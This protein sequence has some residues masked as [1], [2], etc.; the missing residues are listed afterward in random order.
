MKSTLI[1]TSALTLAL[2]TASIMPA[3]AEFTA[4]EVFDAVTTALVQSGVQV[5][6]ASVTLGS[7]DDV[8]ITGLTV[9]DGADAATIPTAELRD[10][11][12]IAD[13]VF[14]IGEVFVPGQTFTTPD[15]VE[16]TYGDIS[17]EDLKVASKESGYKELD[18]GFYSTANIDGISFKADD[19][20]IFSAASMD[21]TVTPF[22]ADKPMSSSMT[23]D[24]ILFNSSGVTDR[25]AREMMRALGYDQLRGDAVI[26]AVWDPSNGQL[27]VT[28]MTLSAE[29][30]ADISLTLDVRGYTAD[31][32]EAMRD[33]QSD[34][35]SNN[36]QASGM[37]MLGMLQQLEFHSMS[38]KLKDESLTGRVL[39]FVATQQGMDRASVT[40]LAKGLLPL[41]LS[42][43]QSPEFAANAQQAVSTYLDDPDTLTV[44]AKPD[45]AVPFALFMAPVM[46]GNPN[47]LLQILNVTVSAND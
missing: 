26:N 14:E 47:T 41:G 9:G 6:A 22:E 1:R 40:A 11:E 36:E 3:H 30:A 38:V 28:D 10:V 31:V 46:N 15:G 43:L 2:S 12:E 18:N 8:K 29:D 34:M 25:R 39:D 17:V 45:N 7:G 32:A 37:A 21:V 4:Q 16:I 13:G 42:Q 20:D 24:R 5:D 27:A 33:I 44:S 19:T 35:G 23:V